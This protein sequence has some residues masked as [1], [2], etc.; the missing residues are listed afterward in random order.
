MSLS[1]MKLKQC[2]VWMPIKVNQGLKLFDWIS[3]AKQ[4]FNIVL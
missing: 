4:V 1:E 3:L 2:C